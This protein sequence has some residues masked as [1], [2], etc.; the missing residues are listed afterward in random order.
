VPGRFDLR[1]SAAAASVPPID[2]NFPLGIAAGDPHPTG[3]VIW[4]KVP[5]SPGAVAV[6]WEV[7][8]DEAF[9]RIARRGSTEAVAETDHTVKV[10]VDG[11]RSDAWYFYRFRTA[12][13][14]SRVGRLRTAPVLGRSPQR[15][16]FAFSSCQ[17][18]NESYYVAHLAMAK[19]DIDFW[20]HY[21]DYIY[22][23]D[24]GTISLD[25]YRGVYRRFKANPML[26]E[27]HARYPVVAMWDDG[28]FVNG[29]DRTFDPARFDAARQAWF[30]YQPV[31]RP[32]RD[33]NR[34][35]RKIGWG[36]LVSFLL[37]DVRQYRDPVINGV[38]GGP[39]GLSTIDTHTEAGAH[40]FDPNRTCLGQRQKHW[41]TSHL[42]SDEATWRHIGH[43][44][45]FLAVRLDDYDTPSA[46]ANPP[47]GFHI[48]GG[49]YVATDAWDSYWAERRRLMDF[50]A[51]QA[52]P[53]VVAT[54]GHTHV[55]FAGGLRPDYDDL[56]GSPVV[57][58]EFVC[59]S[60]TADPDLR[61][62]Y[63]PDLPLEE[64]EAV[65]RSV[66]GAFLGL[67]PQID[68]IDLV[69]QGYGLVEFTPSEARVWFQVIDTYDALAEARTR[70][71]WT[72]PA[73]ASGESATLVRNI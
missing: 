6:D 4:S 55:Y 51:D 19:E 27:L 5:D 58:H 65:L 69:S 59:G 15:L 18:I 8:N 56:E 34:T 57:A 61:K 35:Y 52:I 9:S 20:V 49:N 2:P 68:Y 47:A 42:A 41:L 1:A 26:Q 32:E 70:A 7:A 36:D 12:A 13:G 29:I 14:T 54:A 10:V 40:M 53:N 24:F 64:A 72:V 44:Y 46:R 71:S 67:N 25:D 11:L 43:G 63:L 17:Q 30:D 38:S 50:L 45:N 39:L 21:G 60:L 3:S 28:E 66:E 37:L 16:R 23:N 33:P 73:V 62:A 22:V 31:T 48:N